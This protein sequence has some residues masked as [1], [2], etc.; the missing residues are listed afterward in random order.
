MWVPSVA[1]KFYQ[2]MVNLQYFKMKGLRRL[3]K[4]IPNIL[5]LSRIP[6][7]FSITACLFAKF[8]SRYAVSFTLCVVASITDYLDGATARKFN[9]T[10]DFGKLFDA[11]C[12]KILTV[13]IF[14]SFIAT[15][16]YPPLFV[17][18]TLIVL[19]REF[20]VT[21]LRMI[22]ASRGVVMAAERGGKVKTA[23]QMFAIC[24]I[25]FSYTLEEANMSD[26][27]LLNTI[28]YMLIK[29][30]RLASLVMFLFSSVLALMSGYTYL[31][32]Y[33]YLISDPSANCTTSRSAAPNPA[34][35]RA[36][37]PASKPYDIISS[38]KASSRP[39]RASAVSIKPEASDPICSPALPAPPPPKF[40]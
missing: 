14:I 17:F 4:Q 1:S 21:G 24:A 35:G 34:V 6:L 23:A 31:R 30:I 22:A 39:S 28:L 11:L 15:G 37:S 18:P 12:D 27:G 40:N 2:S 10:S 26:G 38:S 19:S 8:P 13:G 32:K 20:L 16:I 36:A 7:L 33:S 5:S 3:V 29:P 9:A 25:L